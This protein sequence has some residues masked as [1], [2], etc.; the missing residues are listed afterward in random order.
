MCQITAST[1][2]KGVKAF[3]SQCTTEQCN[4]VDKQH[5]TEEIGLPKGEDIAIKYTELNVEPD[6][7]SKIGV[8]DDTVNR[9]LF[10]ETG[11]LRSKVALVILHKSDEPSERSKSPEPTTDGKFVNV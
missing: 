9:G 3:A 2:K 4:S 6:K 8:S 10:A 7:F 11:A 5:N 1:D